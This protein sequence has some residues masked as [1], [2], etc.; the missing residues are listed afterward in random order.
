MNNDDVRQCRGGTDGRVFCQGYKDKGF[1]LKLRLKEEGRLP[2][3][4]LG[5]YDFAGTGIYS[6]EY[7]V[8]SYGL[9]NIDLHFGLGWGQL[10]GLNNNINNPLGYIYDGFNDR[11]FD[12]GGATGGQF[13]PS[14]YFS[15]ETVSPFYGISYSLNSKLFLKIEKDPISTNNPFEFIKY[16]ERKSNFSYGLNYVINNNF[17]IGA[18]YER[19]N[20]L[21]FKINY[22][23][24]PSSNIKKYKYQKPDLD[25]DDSDDKYTKLIK[26]LEQN[27][28]GVNRI[29][30][31]SRSLG[32]EL[33]QFI[34][35]N[36][37]QV[38]QIIAQA[39]REAGINKSIKKDLKIADLKAVSE[40]DKNFEKN[41]TLIYKKKKKEV[42]IPQPSL[43]SDHLL[44][45]ERLF[46]KELF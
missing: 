37:N 1:N 42:S 25:I 28:I 30:E 45:R 20:Y 44:H 12:L 13:K 35:P 16:P 43:N 11:P 46:L 23:N 21:S 17:S 26:N 10:N 22:K 6:S 5:L 40:I 3:L 39:S 8:A 4:A 24:N 9:N 31:G 15:G 14:Q 27:G 7:I 36:L 33:T 18:S 19:G 34:H 32:L 41:S 29:I 38:E 2:A